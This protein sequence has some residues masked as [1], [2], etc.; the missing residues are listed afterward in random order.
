MVRF[1]W[2]AALAACSSRSNPTPSEPSGA[3]P[4]EAAPLPDP[5]A[6]VVEVDVSGSPGAYT[7]AVTIASD[8]TGCD[9]Y[10]DWWEVVTVADEQL[11]Y[12]RIL[13]H[14][15]PD[16]QPFT[17]SGG[18]IAVQPDDAI[19]VR[20]HLAPVGYAGD[21]VRGTVATGLTTPDRAESLATG[22]ASAEPQPMGC[23]F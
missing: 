19:L 9:R 12:R 1:V 20:A 22:L 5:E 6:S 4:T 23:L 18:P 14:S 21:A 17:R 7:F 8:E 13:T 15:H 16:E 11:V 2:I 3:E 10:A